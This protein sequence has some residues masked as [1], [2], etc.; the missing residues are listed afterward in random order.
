MYISVYNN[1]FFEKEPNSYS[2]IFFHMTYQSKL[3]K[4]KPWVTNQLHI[5]VRIHAI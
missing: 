4:I 2:I 5:T 3:G 1:D